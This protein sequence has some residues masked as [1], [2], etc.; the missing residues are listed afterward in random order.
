M[1]WCLGGDR[2]V[3]LKQD[4]SQVDTT[5]SKVVGAW[6][7]MIAFGLLL[8]FPQPKAHLYAHLHTHTHMHTHIHAH[9]HTHTHLYWPVHATCLPRKILKK[10]TLSVGWSGGPWIAMSSREFF[11]FCFCKF[12]CI[13]QILDTMNAFS[14]QKSLLIILSWS[15]RMFVLS[16]MTSG[17]FL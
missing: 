9:V 6:V 10:L 7:Y 8:H 14:I 3:W 2:S 11:C 15:S 5:W 16:C 17:K 12:I 4:Y 13:F 1:L